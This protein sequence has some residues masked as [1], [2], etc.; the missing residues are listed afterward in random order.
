MILYMRAAM[1]RAKVGAGDTAIMLN[2]ALLRD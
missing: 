1:M 2:P